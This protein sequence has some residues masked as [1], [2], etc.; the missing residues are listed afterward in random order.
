MLLGRHRK[1]INPQAHLLES[2]VGTWKPVLPYAVN[3][4]VC[5]QLLR[6]P[7]R[8]Q[9]TSSVSEIS[10]DFSGSSLV[11]EKTQATL[12]HHVLQDRARRN[13]DGAPLA[14]D[15]DDSPLQGDA[16]TKIDGAGDGEMVKLDDVGDAGDA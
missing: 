7:S 15:D 12:H 9:C 11:L 10:V 13:I 8:L 2:F 4:S 3:S 1:S 16:A 5:T 6:M 14:A